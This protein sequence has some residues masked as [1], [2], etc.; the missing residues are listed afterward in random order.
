MGNVVKGSDMLKASNPA[1]TDPS[2]INHLHL[3]L[4]SR[5]FP[6]NDVFSGPCDGLAH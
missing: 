2:I 3:I 1:R 4:S 5:L 6:L